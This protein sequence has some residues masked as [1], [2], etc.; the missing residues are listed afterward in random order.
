MKKE[1]DNLLLAFLPQNDLIEDKGW[2]AK[3]KDIDLDCN[4]LSDALSGDNI[5]IDE[6]I[7]AYSDCINAY[8][9]TYKIHTNGEIENIVNE[10]LKQYMIKKV[11]AEISNFKL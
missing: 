7:E 9:T 11:K 10:E 2:N 1:I 6:I 5:A 3:T 8:C 4:K